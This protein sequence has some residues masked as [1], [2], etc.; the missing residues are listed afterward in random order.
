MSW[1]PSQLGAWIIVAEVEGKVAQW[2][3]K[4]RKGGRVIHMEASPLPSTAILSFHIHSACSSSWAIQVVLPFAGV[5]NSKGL[6]LPN[7]FLRSQ[8]NCSAVASRWIRQRTP[9]NT[10]V[11]LPLSAAGSP[12]C[13][14]PGPALTQF[15]GSLGG[16][17]FHPS[18]SPQCS[19]NAQQGGL[20]LITVKVAELLYCAAP[21][22]W[23]WLVR[24][25]CNQRVDEKSVYVK[26]VSYTTP[27]KEQKG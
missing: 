19:S 1:S 21:A 14:T 7:V 16:N 6:C 3:G 12:A 24:S 25:V 9:P 10:P 5:V 26:R 20:N 11:A 27:S 8:W 13:R 15:R 4:R 17:A 22:K 2:K 18:N 23:V